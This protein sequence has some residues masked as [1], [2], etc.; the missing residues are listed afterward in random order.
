MYSLMTIPINWLTLILVRATQPG[1][2]NYPLFTY[3]EPFKVAFVSIIFEWFCT[4]GPW[5]FYMPQRCKLD[6]PAMRTEP[7]NNTNI[8][9]I[10]GLQFIYFQILFHIFF[11]FTNLLPCHTQCWGLTSNPD[12]AHWEIP[13]ENATW[14]L[15]HN[16]VK[17]RPNETMVDRIWTNPHELHAMYVNF[18][19]IYQ[20]IIIFNFFNIE[21]KN[22]MVDNFKLLKEQPVM[23]ILTFLR[24]FIYVN[25]HELTGY[26][27]GVRDPYMAFLVWYQKLF[28]IIICAGVYPFITY[29]FPLLD[30]SVHWEKLAGNDPIAGNIYEDNIRTTMVTNRKVRRSG[31]IKRDAIRKAGF[32]ARRKI[33]KGIRK[34]ISTITQIAS[35]I[36]KKISRATVKSVTKIGNKLSKMSFGA[37]SQ[38]NKSRTTLGGASQ[39]RISIRSKTSKVSKHSRASKTSV[40]KQGNNNAA[41]KKGKDVKKRKDINAE[42]TD[43]LGQF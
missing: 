22:H 18:I 6:K 8:I 11:G 17:L 28:L 16:H 41:A 19:G 4:I 30:G 31:F 14:E 20:I 37:K 9:K 42:I 27:D 26:T 23:Y 32:I 25:S 10:Y 35:N 2:S 21:G 38:R 13:I 36:S 39:S 5:M 12:A 40:S 1:Y 3:F 15:P 7:I 29:M 33:Y 34:A 24:L 43:M